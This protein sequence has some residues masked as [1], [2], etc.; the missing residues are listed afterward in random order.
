MFNNKKTKI[1]LVAM[2]ISLAILAIVFY[3][4]DGLLGDKEFS[5]YT[6]SDW[7][8]AILPLSIMAI[9]AISTLTFALVLIVPIFRIYPALT[10]YVTNQKF[11]DIDTDIEFLVFDHDEFKRAC[12]KTN[13]E[14]KVWFSVKEYDIKQK[15]WTI[16]E[17]GR[18]TENRNTLIYVLQQDYKFDKVKFYQNEIS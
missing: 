5:E 1:C 14:N 6:S 2:L 12:C 18:V 13:A 4:T 15:N 17:E 11:S 3:G 7:S 8:V 9:S 16:L 10:D